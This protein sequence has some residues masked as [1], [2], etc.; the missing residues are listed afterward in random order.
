MRPPVKIAWSAAGLALLVSASGMRMPG[1]ECLLGVW[2]AGADRWGAQRQ[3]PE[4]VHP[5]DGLATARGPLERH[6]GCRVQRL[7]M[8]SIARPTAVIGK[9]GA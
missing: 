3:H 6:H 9:N 4:E 5:T 8:N 2:L 7:G 1:S